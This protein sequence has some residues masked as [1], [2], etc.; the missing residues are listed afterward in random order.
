MELIYE[1]SIHMDE[2]SVPK[3]SSTVAEDEFS[4][5][6]SVAEKKLIRKCDLH[7]LPMISILYI[8]SFVDRI[9]IGN[10]RIQGLE[11]DLH[12]KGNDYN[13]ALFMFFIPYVLVEVPSNLLIKKIAPSTWLSFLMVSW[14]TVFLKY[15]LKSCGFGLTGCLGIVT[16]CQGVTKSFAGLVVCRVLLGFFEAGFVP[17]KYQRQ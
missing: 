7:V 4:P 3:S 8:L 15:L 9:N 12:M 16:I 11:A 14:G 6:D 10:A 5:I 2:T 1:K 13:I 17:G